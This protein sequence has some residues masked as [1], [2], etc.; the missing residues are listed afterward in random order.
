MQALHSERRYFRRIALRESIDV[1]VMDNSNVNGVA[2]M[3]QPPRNR[4]LP[5]DVRSADRASVIHPVRM[6]LVLDGPGLPW[7]LFLRRTAIQ[8]NGIGEIDLAPQMKSPGRTGARSGLSLGNLSTSLC[9]PIRPSVVNVTTAL[10]RT[11]TARRFPLPRTVE[12][13]RGISYI[14]R[15]ANDFPVAY[16]YFE[17]ERGRRAARRSTGVEPSATANLMTKDEAR[18]IAAGIAKLPELLKRPRD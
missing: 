17:S 14:V 4:R 2:K 1:T 15:D 18:K 7:G 5:T 8:S 9:Q 10:I 13:Y 12:E 16:V 3:I 6:A 11:I